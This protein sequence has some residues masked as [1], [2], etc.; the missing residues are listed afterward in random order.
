MNEIQK[1]SVDGI[2]A[3]LTNGPGANGTGTDT[4]FGQAAQ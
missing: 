3:V 4:G 2:W 1:R